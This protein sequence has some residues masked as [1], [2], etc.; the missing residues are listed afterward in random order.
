MPLSHQPKKLTR[1]MMACGLA[2]CTARSPSSFGLGIDT[3]RIWLILFRVCILSCVPSKTA[4]V[5]IWMKRYSS[6]HRLLP[7]HRADSVFRIF[8]WP[9]CF[10]HSSRFAKAA[11]L[12]SQSGRNCIQHGDQR[13]AGR[14]RSAL[15]TGNGADF[16]L[17]RSTPMTSCSRMASIARLIPRSPLA[18]VINIRVM[19]Q[20]PGFRCQVSGFR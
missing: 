8:A 19:C 12:I 10:S 3:Q 16:N 1:A 5:E 9:G 11:Q 14:R 6:L 4:S 13:R 7:V 15:I 17:P 20:V 2:S 18:P